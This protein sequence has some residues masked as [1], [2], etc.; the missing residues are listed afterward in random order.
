MFPG[1]VNP[2]EADSVAV[3]IPGMG[4]Q[5]DA[6]VTIEGMV[7]E[8]TLIQSEAMTPLETAGGGHETVA[9][10]AW[11]G[12]DNPPWLATAGSDSRATEAAPVL[13][14]YLESFGATNSG[15]NTPAVIAGL[16]ESAV[17][18]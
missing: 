18:T 7:R 6:D 4:S 1:A 15:Y 16:P 10:V 14:R 5:I 3:T 2:D 11:L 17:R 13:F 8:G 9:T 12:Y